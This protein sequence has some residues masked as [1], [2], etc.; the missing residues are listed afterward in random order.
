MKMAKTATGNMKFEF[1][2]TLV[3]YFT[4]LATSLCG[5]IQRMCQRRECLP[6]IEPFK[7]LIIYFW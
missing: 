4:H 6:C 7:S 5:K 3:S 2:D 1:R